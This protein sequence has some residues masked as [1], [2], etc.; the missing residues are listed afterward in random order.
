[1]TEQVQSQEANSEIPIPT[2]LLFE[3][4]TRKE[5]AS[6]DNPWVI[7]PYLRNYLLPVTYNININESVWTEIYPEAEMDDYEA[8]FQISFKALAWAYILGQ[9]TD[10]WVAYTQENWS[11]LHNTDASSPFH[12]TN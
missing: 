7:T 2:R 11:Q 4:R 5:H 8:K 10:L 1:M 6:A 3:E 9:S 12:E